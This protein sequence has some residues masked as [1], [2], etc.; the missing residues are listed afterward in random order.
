[1][2]VTGQTLRSLQGTAQGTLV[3]PTE[4]TGV[5]PAVALRKTGLYIAV[6]AVSAVP[7]QK[8]VDGL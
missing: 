5:A 2:S 1:M 8:N 7:A 6:L 3:S 4:I